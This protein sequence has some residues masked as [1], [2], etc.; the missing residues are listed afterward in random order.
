[1]GAKRMPTMKNNGK[2][3]LGVKIGLERESVGGKRAE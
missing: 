1:M 3:L 2:T